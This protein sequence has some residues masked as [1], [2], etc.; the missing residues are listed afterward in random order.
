MTWQHH[1]RSPAQDRSRYKELKYGKKPALCVDICIHFTGRLGGW[2]GLE[3]M[4]WREGWGCALSEKRSVPLS[5]S[6]TAQP[7]PLSVKPLHTVTCG[8]LWRGNKTKHPVHSPSS[9]WGR[10]I[11]LRALLLHCTKKRGTHYTISLSSILIQLSPRR[12]AGLKGSVFLLVTS[13]IQ[14]HTENKNHSFFVFFPGSLAMLLHS[15]VNSGGR[16]ARGNMM[17]FRNLSQGMRLVS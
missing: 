7:L 1:L 5:Q 16:P 3:Y 17:A 12:T 6:A 14:Y 13:I 10:C 11:D 4:I 9:M 2:G 8:E 15:D